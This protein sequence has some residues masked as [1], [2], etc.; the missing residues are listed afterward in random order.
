[1]QISSL[2]D[3]NTHLPNE[4][5]T[6]TDENTAA[7]QISAA[8]LIRAQLSNIVDQAT[9]VGWNTPDNTPDI[10]REI[11]A[12]LIAAQLYFNE[13]AKGTMVLETNSF[14]QIK[15]NNAMAALTSII[16]GQITL[17]GLVE[18]DADEFT[19]ND[20]FPVDAT[21]RAFTMGQQL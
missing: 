7:L 19:V 1:M 12:M 8:R 13:V 21:D 18:T 5:V 16:G 17:P 20:F 14:A 11:G 9:M 6:A 15:Y 3:I 4:V 10:I 2:D